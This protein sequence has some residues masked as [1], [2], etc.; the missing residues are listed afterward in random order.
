MVNDLDALVRG[1]AIGVA[2]QLTAAFLRAGPSRPRAWIGALYAA[3]AIA[4][5]LWGAAGSASWPWRLHGLVGILALSCPFFVWALARSIFEDDFRLR[6]AHWIILAGIVITGV[7]QSALARVLDPW[8]VT[9]LRVGFRLLSLALIVHVFGLMWS[10]WQASLVDKRVRLR[11]GVLICAATCA[12]DRRLFVVG[13]LQE[14]EKTRKQREDWFY[15]G[16][17]VVA[18]LTLAAIFAGHSALALCQRSDR[19]NRRK[20]PPLVARCRAA[21]L[22][23]LSGMSSQLSTWNSDSAWHV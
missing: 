15:W 14:K 17:L 1:A 5:L 9:T 18:C 8:I 16:T 4:C 2:L 13:W 3:G 21:A 23:G 11:F 10:G 12:V 7:A 19:A 6:A 20:K 22:L